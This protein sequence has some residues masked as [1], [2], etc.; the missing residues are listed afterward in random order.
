MR[1]AIFESWVVAETIKHRWNL[2]LPA[3]IYFWRDNHGTE[4]DLLFESAGQLHA[5]EV[6]SGATFSPDWL[7]ACHR[8]QG[9]AGAVAASPVLVYGG[10]DS[11]SVQGVQVMAWHRLGA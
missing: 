7:Q 4:I 9:Y 10:R 5:V 8:W 3:D 11:Y 2:G 1:G 6:K